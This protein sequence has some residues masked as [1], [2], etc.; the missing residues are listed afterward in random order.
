MI[1]SYEPLDTIHYDLTLKE[2]GK[3]SGD[4]ELET[5]ELHIMFI[6]IY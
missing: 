3:D 4:K 6:K 2:W 1:L 5:Y